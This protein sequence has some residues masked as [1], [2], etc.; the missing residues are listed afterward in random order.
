MKERRK[1]RATGRERGGW[2][3]NDVKVSD[4]SNESRSDTERGIAR[5]RASSTRFTRPNSTRDKTL[6]DKARTQ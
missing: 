3:E 4:E 2:G 6:P 1:T 5:S